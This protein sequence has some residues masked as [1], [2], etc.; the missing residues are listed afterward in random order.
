MDIAFKVRN[1]CRRY[2][3]YALLVP[4]LEVPFGAVALVGESG[5]G[6]STLLNMLAALDV[7]YS[8]RIEY[9]GRA[10]TGDLDAHRREVAGFIF[11][12][13]NLLSNFRVSK[14]VALSRM[15]GG[16]GVDA[17]TERAVLGTLFPRNGTSES[18][19][20]RV[21]DRLNDRYPSELSGGQ[22]QRVA[23]A[24]A[25]LKGEDGAP[26]IFADEP[27][28]NIDPRTAEVCFQRLLSWRSEGK[29]L[30]I[31]ATHDLQ[32][33][34]RSD[35]I[36]C[37]GLMTGDER[38]ALVE[39]FQSI[40][41]F[42]PELIPGD[43]VPVFGVRCTGVTDV[44]WPSIQRL[45]VGGPADGEA[46]RASEGQRRLSDVTSAPARTDSIG[47]QPR[48][49]R[50][51][52]FTLEYTWREISRPREW[53]DNVVRLG[54]V[55][56]L[57]VWI[58]FAASLFVGV[59]RVTRSVYDRDPL[60]RLVDIRSVG[61]FPLESDDLRALAM[62]RIDEGRVRP[63]P[64]PADPAP[65]V[66]AGV[67][68]KRDCSLKLYLRDGTVSSRWSNRVRRLYRSGAEDDPILRYWGLPPLPAR[69]GI[70]VRAKLLQELGYD[71]ADMRRRAAAADPTA[72]LSVDDFDR[73]DLPVLAVV[74]EIPDP[75]VDLLITSDLAQKLDAKDEA[76]RASTHRYVSFQ[77]YR[78]MQEAREDEGRF[79]AGLGGR[80]AAFSEFIEPAEDHRPG[81][82]SFR[83]RVLSRE[84]DGLTRRQWDDVKQLFEAATNLGRGFVRPMVPGPRAFAV[85]EER[86]AP[87]ATSNQATLFVLEYGDVPA[88]LDHVERCETS[89]AI[90]AT[91]AQN[92]QYVRT[93]QRSSELGALVIG[94][95]SAALML[96][97][98]ISL[99]YSF[100]PTIQR[101]LGEIGILRAYG[102]GLGMI[103][104]RFLLELLAVASLGLGLATGA[105]RS[106]L[107]PALNGW[108]R[109]L[110]PDV[111]GITSSG[112][113]DF[114]VGGVV[115]S[116][117][118]MTV[119]I[120]IVGGVAY[121]RL[122]RPPAD[123]VSMS[124]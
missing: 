42:P 57:F 62:L 46:P 88:V 80:A 11:Q 121:V 20:D 47:P 73:V 91:N 43:D 12:S 96:M 39:H 109:S 14:N 59:P 85:V 74:D 111:F 17:P 103:V 44:T 15:L 28:A 78:S 4:E 97:G 95:V 26:T 32:F 102:G 108:A 116:L 104:A 101:K 61:S 51:S 105:W 112:P 58:A 25:L 99:A 55:W 40:S 79:L 9:D 53:F 7:E 86:V 54:V 71:V 83:I 100:I 82:P 75:Q 35:W 113:L 33:A 22:R 98:L 27:T 106:W 66:L 36:V 60:L 48:R 68:L 38:R 10:L 81:H 21:L 65:R 30:L 31:F 70:V 52:A 87:S 50:S 23:V 6:K 118:V 13:S 93:V 76:L 124:Y 1:L 69:P 123:L 29:R 8:G 3:G 18:D 77:G 5:A 24:R 49:T 45:L 110:A 119:A 107:L 89:L 16:S 63:P 37:L 64:G 94:S 114:E 34:R 92:K 72:L 122:R 41:G 84:P 120:A 117:L 90:K 2:P 56:L 67:S 115:A 19:H